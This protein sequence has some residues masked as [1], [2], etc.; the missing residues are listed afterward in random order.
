M[1]G[2]LLSPHTITSILTHGRVNSLYTS[3]LSHHFSL[4]FGTSCLS[5]SDWSQISKI[6]NTAA[7]KTFLYDTPSPLLPFIVTDL[8]VV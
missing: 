5:L 7:F 3:I 6:F 8:Y 2:F 4:A 1:W